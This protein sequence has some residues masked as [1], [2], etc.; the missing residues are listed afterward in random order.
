M[1]RRL[2]AETAPTLHLGRPAK[3][4]IKSYPDVWMKEMKMEEQKS[5]KRARINISLTAKGLA[6]F[7][8]AAG[9][10]IRQGRGKAP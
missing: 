4:N 9:K 10:R 6:R 2:R 7:D 8:C 1:A 5:M 3:A